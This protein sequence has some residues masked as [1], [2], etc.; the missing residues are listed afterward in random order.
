[1]VVCACVENGQELLD[2]ARV[3][4]ALY[5]VG[6]PIKLK[7][8][9]LEDIYQDRNLAR[10]RHRL[11]FER[12]VLVV[13]TYFGRKKPFAYYPP[14]L[15]ALT[16][17]CT[18]R[19]LLSFCQGSDLAIVGIQSV[20]QRML[21][22]HFSNNM[23]FVSLHRAL[24]FRTHAKVNRAHEPLFRFADNL[25]RMISLQ[26]MLP[27]KPGVGY[28]DYYFELG[29]VNRDYLVEQGVNSRKVLVTGSP[30]YD[31]FYTESGELRDITPRSFSVTQRPARLCYVTG[32]YEWIGDTL[33]EG[34]QRRK[35]ANLVEFARLQSDVKVTIRVHPR[36]PREKYERLVRMYPH[37]RLEYY[38][39]R[40]DVFQDLEK[41][42]VVI[43]TISQVMYDSVLMGKTAIF[44]LLPE[45]LER[46][47]K[48]FRKVGLE[49]VQSF[50]QVVNLI[51]MVLAGR[52]ARIREYTDVQRSAVR[53]IIYLPEI[54]P[55][56][57]IA[58]NLHRLLAQ[59]EA[60]WRK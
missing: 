29:Q 45:E 10:I 47:E 35:I 23:L 3:V 22:A 32:A 38:D 30:T 53:K 44:Y 20:F 48:F 37:I 36:E 26:F 4:R 49:T 59:E 58:K 50:E 46:Y 7:L 51:E 28:A 14:L 41:Y 24:L 6:V 43:G 12:D 25:V 13:P 60:H 56:E 34:F 31:W 16:V 33:G 54:K 40:R 2:L 1:M 8:V 9:S 5:A 57:L 21:Y 39:P 11:P 52:I 42:D 18:R 27:V 15:K 19:K 55:S 17:L